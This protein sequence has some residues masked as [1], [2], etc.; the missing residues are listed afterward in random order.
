MCFG[1]CQQ[2]S[3]GE[4]WQEYLAAHLGEPLRNFG[5]GGYGV[6]Q[7]YRRARRVEATR[8]GAD[9][10]ILSIYDDDHVRNLDASRWIRTFAGASEAPADRPVML[11]GIPW[12]HVRLNMQ[13]GRFE[14]RP[15]LCPTP[16]ALR[17]LCDPQAFYATF[18]DDLIVHLFTIQNGGQAG[19]LADLEA[20]AER[21]G[22]KVDLRNPA[23]RRK[24]ARRLRIEY[25]L[26]STEYVL[27][28]WL[29]WFRAQ[30]K[31]LLVLLCYGE[32]RILEA[33]AGQ[34]RFDQRF[35]DYL[36]RQGVPFVDM[37]TRHAQDYRA[38]KI[39]P[40]AYIDRFYIN[41]AGAAV[42]GHYNPA[43]NHFYAFGIKDTVVQWLHPKPPAYRAD[44]ASAARPEMTTT[45]SPA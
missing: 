17:R 40:Q 5:S 22:V 38:F 14:E 33:V 36:T 34:P 31:K 7:C 29:E 27:D 2:V 35:L 10:A 18:K 44:R 32:G 11:H 12:A 3:D 39:E 37:L 16:D 13:T 30:K 20:L 23:V 41:A 15:S 24:E 9:Y 8:L 26:R 19:R 25:G 45:E 21:L 4:T 43:A 42:F 6:Y 28:Q 1:Q